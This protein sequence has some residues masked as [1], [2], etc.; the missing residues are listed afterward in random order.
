MKDLSKMDPIEVEIQFKLDLR[1][2]MKKWGAALYA[3][4]GKL[5]YGMCAQVG[6]HTVTLGWSFNQEG[7]KP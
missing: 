4:E 5:D 2:L 6:A 3:V 7:E 1:K